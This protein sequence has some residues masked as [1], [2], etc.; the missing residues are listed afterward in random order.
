MPSPI[1]RVRWE[2]KQANQPKKVQET[3]VFCIILILFSFT[4][5]SLEF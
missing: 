4:L 3:P 1:K 5:K 2:G